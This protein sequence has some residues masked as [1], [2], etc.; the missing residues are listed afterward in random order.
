MRPLDS[1]RGSRLFERYHPLL[2][3]APV[4]DRLRP[5]P[6]SPEESRA[7][8]FATWRALDAETDTPDR[9]TLAKA[10]RLADVAR[11]LHRARTAKARLTS[12]LGIVRYLMAVITRA[13]GVGAAGIA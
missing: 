12:A 13:W 1:F 7:R 4:A 6:M 3:S 10:R 5:S 9:E 2:G 8:A 11:D